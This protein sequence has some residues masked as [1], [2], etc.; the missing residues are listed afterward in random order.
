LRLRPFAAA[1]LDC[2][3]ALFRES[4]RSIAGRDYTLD[5]VLAWAPDEIDRDLWLIRLTSASTWVAD[6]GMRA[7]GF[8]SLTPSGLIDMLYVSP[9]FQRRG[10][11]TA[12]LAYLE[13]SAR[14]RGFDRLTT[15]ASIPARHFFE[16]QGF[17]VLAA[18]TVTRRGQA[19]RNFRMARSILQ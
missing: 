3:I 6:E 5:Q 1:E 18:Q 13:Q 12:L 9:E 19:L 15:A 11:A 14:C 2:L 17:R 10:I 16:A 8:I 7:A 4:V